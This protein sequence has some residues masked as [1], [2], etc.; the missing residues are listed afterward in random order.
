MG[1]GIPNPKGRLFCLVLYPD[2]NAEHQRV[3]DLLKKQYMILGICHNR[4]VWHEYDD[5]FA[6]GE[7]YEGEIKKAHHHVIV[8]FENARYLC[9]L[10]KE[11][12][13]EPNLIRKLGSFRSMAIYLTHRDYPQRAQYKTDEFYGLLIGDL[14][15]VIG[16]D[17]PEVQLLEI[18]TYLKGLNSYMSYTDFNIF[19]CTNGYAS[20][21][22]KYGSQ[23]RDCFY[24]C[25]G[26]YHA[27]QVESK[28]LKRK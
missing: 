7:H 20:T 28:L 13:C 19:L 12:G 9:A 23:I 1:K 15:K 8:K 5:N 26:K 24:E 25:Q 10:A 2:D 21:L 27:K 14:M 4:D 3:L 16:D 6:E 22:K 18:L 11:L 17:T